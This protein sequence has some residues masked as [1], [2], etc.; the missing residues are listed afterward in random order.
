[1][2]GQKEASGLA[3]YLDIVDRLV[4]ELSQCSGYEGQGAG[5]VLQVSVSWMD[6]LWLILHWFIGWQRIEMKAN[7][8]GKQ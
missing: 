6:I 3:V 1:M 5:H 8:T 7:D 4:E 2:S